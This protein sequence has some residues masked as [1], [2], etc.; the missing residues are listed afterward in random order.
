MPTPFPKPNRFEPPRTVH[1]RPNLARRSFGPAWVGFL[2]AFWVVAMAGVCNADM[3]SSQDKH[4]SAASKRIAASAPPSKAKTASKAVVDK[5]DKAK[6]AETSSIYTNDVPLRKAYLRGSLEILTFLG[7]SEAYYLGTYTSPEWYDFK[8]IEDSLEARF[9]TGKAYRL[10]PNSF[11][12]NTGHVAAGTS[13]YLIA[14]SNGM[15]LPQS[16]LATAGA[17]TLWELFGE[18]HDEF[19]INDAIMTPFAGFST[20]ETMYQLGEFFQHSAPTITNRTLGILFDPLAAANR[21]MDDTQPQPPSRVDEFGFTTDAWH[22][23]RV[24]AGGGGDFSGGGGQKAVAEAGLDFEVVTAEKYG[25][26]GEVCVFDINGMFNELS[27]EQ[28]YSGSD[29]L[30]T[31]FVA[32]TAFLGQYRQNI[33]QDAATQDQEGYGLFLGLGSAF[34]YYGQ[35]FEG[36]SREDRLAIVDLVGPTLIADYYHCGVHVRTSLDAYPTF[37]MVQPAVGELYDLNHSLAGTQSVYRARGYYYALGVGAGLKTEV[38]YGPFDLEGLVQYDYFSSIQGLDRVQENVTNELDFQDQRLWLQ[39]ILYS[40]LPCDNLKLGVGAER[41]FRWSDISP[42][43]S[44]NLND[45]RYFA[46]I[47]Y[48]F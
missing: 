44:S 27:F 18:Y 30:D 1:R 31:R 12:M 23:F 34:E 22:R 19:S 47:V 7:V 9:I 45:T 2:L 6:A 36:V 35:M 39:L 29:L 13:F 20:G 24:Y 28:A 21:W 40:K 42:D 26:P 15:D 16:W 14:R 48:Q 37:S 43:F 4:V 10:D 32:K 33:L 5:E 3:D 11:D 46:R 8:T 25:K 41:L 38:D 17:S